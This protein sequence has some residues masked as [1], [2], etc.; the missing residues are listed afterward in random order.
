MSYRKNKGFLQASERYYNSGYGKKHCDSEYCTDGCDGEKCG[1]RD[2]CK[3]RNT[4]QTIIDVLCSLIND[5]VDITTPFGVITGTL[6]DV[7]RDYIVVLEDSGDQVL[8][9]TSK[10]ESVSPMT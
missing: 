1:E 3:D 10:I 5:Q 4:L 7:K 8:V 6:L 9:R 2:V